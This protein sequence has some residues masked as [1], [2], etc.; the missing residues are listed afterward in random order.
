MDD[1]DPDSLS[2]EQAHKLILS[3]VVPIQETET[4]NLTTATGRTLASDVNSQ[5]QV[6]PCRNSAM[7]GYA[8]RQKDIVP[9]AATTLIIAGKSLAGHPRLQEIEPN[10]CVRVTTGAAIPPAA[11]CVVM[12]ELVT[13][14][15]GKIIIPSAKM[16]SR[17]IRE[18][19]SDIDF[20]DKVLKRGT[21]LG[22]AELGLLASIGNNDIKTF[23]RPR[24]A[25]FSTGDELVNPGKVPKNGQIFDSN[26]FVLWAQLEQIGAEIIDLGIVNDSIESM[27]DT[28]AKAVTADLLI[29][30]GGVS[31]GEADYV[32]EVLKSCGELQLWKIAMKPGRPLTV[33][34]LNNGCLFFG[35]PGNPVSGMVTFQFF[36][37]AALKKL[38]NQKQEKQLTLSAICLTDLS[39]TPGRVELKRG[40]YSENKRGGWQV[41]ATGNQ[42]SH[43]LTSMVKANCFILLGLETGNVEKGKEVKIIPFSNHF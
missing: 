7:D 13:V 40:I 19:G 43:M 27:R 25:I 39:K 9:N 14:E 20:N 3:L 30:S 10:T 5:I 29:S 23:R 36:V 22:A 38:Q 31:V 32:R 41:E 34:K 16:D 18:A 15:S 33:G 4:V 2:I 1:Y 12:Q 6:P 35:L 24:V 17:F 21:L 37:S 28:F 42:D 11:D 26:R 8:F